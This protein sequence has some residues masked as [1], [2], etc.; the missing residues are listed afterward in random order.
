MT[1][2]ETTTEVRELSRTTAA[3]ATD[4]VIMIAIN[5]AQR[6]FAKEA[7][8]LIKEGYITLAPT[9]DTETNFAIRMTVTGGTDAMAATDVALT[10]TARSNVA[11]AQVATD[12]QATIRAAGAGTA[13]VT[14]STTTWK[15]TITTAVDTTSITIAA[16]SGITYVN[17]LS[18]LGLNADTTT[19]YEVSDS[20]P[21][22]CTVEE[23]LPSDFIALVPPVE[24][25][26][27]ELEQAPFPIFA[28]PQAPG[29]PE[30]YGVRENKI[31]LYPYPTSQKMFHIWYQY[32][33]TAFTDATADAATDLYIPSHYHMGVAYY[34]ASII[35][36]KNHEY[37]ISDRMLARFK[38]YLNKYKLAQA[39]QNPVLTP[40][41]RP[42][43]W[44]RVVK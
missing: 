2:A 31:R 32:A 27:K 25:D 36:E 22:D 9:F 15:F 26:N 17:A 42:R 30:Y 10:G 14:W 11:G 13:T 34:A 28:S 41:W 1:L 20:I 40:R 33:P 21:T 12:L 38:E 5:D 39:N 23:D 44:F 4:S 43:K 6:E 29:T 3:A 18:L 19:G 24:W 16:P 7:H 8:G 37:K 35:A